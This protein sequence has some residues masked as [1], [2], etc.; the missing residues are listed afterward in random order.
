MSVDIEKFEE[1]MKQRDREIA[2]CF[3]PV[4]S[5][6]GRELRGTTARLAILLCRAREDGRRLS[7]SHMANALELSGRTVTDALGRLRSLGLAEKDQLGW[8]ATDS[9]MTVWEQSDRPR[10]KGMPPRSAFCLACA[11]FLF[12]KWAFCPR[13]GVDRSQT[14][15]R[16]LG[17]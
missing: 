15:D 16:H 11:A 17:Q 3:S 12:P 13:C 6:G 2:V 4:L 14:G 10:Q 8:Q 5:V 1:W 7:V 9:L